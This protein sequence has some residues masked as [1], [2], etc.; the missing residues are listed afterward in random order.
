VI[1]LSRYVFEA[2][3]KDEEFILYRGRSEDTPVK[4]LVLSPVVEYPTPESLKRLEH[5]YSLREE[6][7]PSWAARPIAMARHWDRT[8]LVLEDP[9]GVP[10]DRLFGQ[11]LNVAF[12]LRLA[13]RLS[14]AI[15]RLHQRAVI[16]K[17]IKPANVLVN[18]DTGECWLSGFGLASRLPRERQAPDPPESI[19]GTLAYMAPEQTGWMNRSIDSRSDL[20]SLGVTLYQ[21]LTGSLPFTA[22]DPMEWVHCHIARKAVAPSERLENVP[23][24]VSQ[25]IMKLLAKTAEER[26]QTAAGLESDLR[27]CLAEWERQGRIDPFAFGEHDAPDRLMIPEKL[28]GRAR[29]VDTLLASFDRIVESGTPELVLVSG[30]SGIGKSS[31]VNEL[32]RVLVPPR[33]LFASG[34]FDQYKCD[35]PYSTLAQAFQSLARPLLGKSEVELASWRHALLE[36]LGPNGRPIVDLVPELKL[37]IGEQPPVPELSPQQ[38]QGRF[39]LVFRRFIGVFARPEHPLALFL[40]DLQWLDAATLDLLED[41][42]TRPDVQHLMLIGAYRGNEVNSAHPLMRK[43]EAI[44]KAGARVQEIIL[45]PLGREDLGRLVA[46]SLRCEPAQAAPL[47]QVVHQKTGGNPFFAIQFISALAEEGLLAFDHGGGRWSWDPNRI[48]A[49]GYTDNVVEL[50]VGKLN[51]LPLQTQKALQ[52]FACLGNSTEIS[53]LSIVHGTSEEDV[54]SDLWEAVRLEFIVRLKGSYKFVHDRIQEAAYSLIPD[55]L[56]AETYLRIGRR[57]AAHTPPEK[58]EVAIF[59]IV[60]PFNRGAA[61][62]TSRD[63]REQL[64]ELNLHAGERAK[65]STAFAAALKYLIAG[66]ALLGDDCW[67]RRHELAFA[68]ELHRAECEFLTGE[69]A[70]AAERLTM[71]SSRAAN[72]VERAT[73]ACL[74]VDLYTTLNQSDRAVAVCLDY[75]RSTGV[76]WLAHPTEEEGRR[77]YERIWSHLGSRTIEELIELPLMSDPGS[78]ATLDVLTK[79]LPPALFTDANLLSLVICRAVN[80]SLEHGNSDGSCFAY[81]WLGV[82]AGPHFDNYE[83]GFRFGRL[84]YELVEKRGLRRFQARTYVSFGNLVMPWTKHVKTGRDLLRREFEAAN[85]IGDLTFAAYSRLDLNT[86]LLAAGDPLVEVQRETEHGLEFAHKMRFGLVIDRITAQLGLIRTLRGLTQKFGSFDDGQFDEL[87]FEGHLSDNPALALPECWYWTRKLQA[88]FFAGDYAAAVDA[89]LRAQR[90]LWTSPSCFETAEYHFYGALSRAASWDTATADQRQQHFE[91]LT[92]HHRQLEVWAENC[93]ENFANRAALVGAEIARIQGRELDAE[94]LYEQAIRSSRANGFVHNEALA[95]EL[96]ARFY[97]TRGFETVAHAYMRTAWHC[98]LRWGA[99]GKVRQLEEL[100]P[101]LREEAP[102]PA[103]ASTI[104][105]S[106]EQLDLGTVV[107]A[108]HAVAGEIVLEKLIETLMVIALEHAGAERGLLILPHGEELRIAAEART[109]RDGVEVQLQDALVTLSDLPDSLLRYVIRTQESVILDDASVHNLFL[110]DEYVRQR[111]PRSVLC[112]PLLKQVH[113]VGI[114]YLENKLAPRVFTPKRLAMLDLLASQA[115]ISLE[116]AGLYADLQQENIIRKRAEDFLAQGERIGHTGSWGWHVATGLVYWSKEHFRIF[117]YNPETTKPSYSLFMER[118]HPEDR[119]SFEEILNRAVRDKSEYEYDYRI[120]LPD[121]SIKFIRSVGQA[122]VN[123]SGELEFIGT[124]MDI[125]D[126]KRAEEMRAAM[127]RERELFAQQRA[128]QFARANEALRGC[129]DTLASVPELDEFLGQVTAAITGQLGAV[130]STLRLCN[131]EK[132]ILSLEFLFQDGRVMSPAEARYPEAW[133]SWPL[134]DGRFNNCFDQPVTVQRVGDP[135]A[136]ILE[137]KR[138]YLRELGV[139]TVLI[140]PLTSRGQANG[141]LTFRFTEE[142]DFDPEELEIARALATQASLAIHLTGLAKTARQSAVLEERNQLAAEIHDALAQSFTGISMQLGVAE[143]QLAAKE[144][145]PLCQIHRANEIAKFGLAEARRSIL[146]LRSSVIEESGLTTT[147]Q[148]LVEHSNV[149][150][151]L[152]CDFRSD[153]IPE[154]SLPPRIQHELL[155]FAQ[156]AISNA[157]RHA[158]P[159]VVSVRLRWEPPNLILQ[160][161]DNGSGISRASV[162]KSEGFGLSNMRTRAS[163]IDGKLDID[164]ATGHGTSVVLTVPIPS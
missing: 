108:S 72:T 21:V 6:L 50:M 142:R 157:V 130:S 121:R 114:L 30:Y 9:G 106:V 143:E 79:V 36:A 82:I 19:A 111:R 46:E 137:D 22:S 88:R 61:L 105:T 17:D 145:D 131:V 14:A 40:D 31:V 86:N 62:I 109:G 20:Y 45:A 120:V 37:I 147:L 58:R 155:R 162:E 3:R 160:V 83:A 102:I 164:T 64:A 24:P 141:R 13:I 76:E 70:A 144:G 149:A 101:H 74:R 63:E 69:L 12:S 133:Q 48:H 67:E 23:A 42:L 156:E 94:R 95:N 87:R 80:L 100:Y 41:L 7:N 96:A 8:V 107:K 128:T 116:N 52:E 2:L 5:A 163:Q 18:S 159:T 25:I 55:E 154:E 140:I 146:S 152:R 124:V 97:A 99:T 51:R 126:L 53:T 151:R 33:G 90:L 28:Y 123:P 81:V 115:A 91:D 26:Y 16:H 153:N 104:G 122:L 39:Q 93:P 54:H 38:A 110:Q 11:P 4:V 139:K 125:T 59:E 134:D 57:L 75:L 27:H 85:K 66:A 129:L 49:K 150:G 103:P 1:D 127:A 119:F 43:L 73:V 65:A 34:K 32:H 161:K 98:Y 60:N 138:A 15:G 10:L 112:L 117:D 92:A 118:I 89:S 135:Q 56:R 77:E 68:L 47:T 35:I 148:R 44:R 29:E 113:L 71:L 132:N 78:L 136:T 84:G 158:K